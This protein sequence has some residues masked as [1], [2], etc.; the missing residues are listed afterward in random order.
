MPLIV[1]GVGGEWPVPL[2]AAD[3][4]GLLLR[5]LDAPPARR[6]EFISRPERRVFQYLPSLHRAERIADRGLEGSIVYDIARS[7]AFDSEGRALALDDPQVLRLIHRW[8]ALRVQ[9]SER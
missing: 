6:P 5:S 9:Q 7:A 4:R 2:G 8:E 3:I 1:W